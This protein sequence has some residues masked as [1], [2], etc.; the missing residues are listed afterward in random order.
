MSSIDFPDDITRALFREAA[1]CLGMTTKEL[2][3]A[4]RVE[5][6]HALYRLVELGIF[7]NVDI[8]ISTLRPIMCLQPNFIGPDF[9]MAELNGVLTSGSANAYFAYPLKRLLTLHAT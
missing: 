8:T 1:K 3:A 4:I 6:E 9:T 5:D 7:A 2:R